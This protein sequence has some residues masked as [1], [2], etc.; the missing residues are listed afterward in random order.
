L[1]DP[2]LG[3]DPVDHNLMKARILARLQHEET[4][5]L[6]SAATEAK[7][8]K[9]APVPDPT[10]PDPNVVVPRV[11]GVTV[12]NGVT[13]PWTGGNMTYRRT[14]ACGPYAYRPQDIKGRG[15]ARQILTTPIDKIF[16]LGIPMGDSHKSSVVN[17][18]DWVGHISSR[19]EWTR[20]SIC[21]KEESDDSIC[22]CPCKPQLS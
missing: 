6:K 10:Q 16:R 2:P 7:D 21:T 9:P 14:M 12:V 11:G 1:G 22:A 20:S 18:F 19:K 15:K 4:E 13:V 3:I 17:L 5:R 8:T